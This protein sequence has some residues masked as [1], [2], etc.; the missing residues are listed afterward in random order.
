MRIPGTNLKFGL[1]NCVI[2]GKYFGQKRP[3]PVLALFWQY[4]HY[5]QKLSF[6]YTS[7]AYICK[8]REKRVTF[9]RNSFL[10]TYTHVTLIQAKTWA[11]VKGWGVGGAQDPPLFWHTCWGPLSLWRR[12][13]SLPTRKRLYSQLYKAN[14]ASRTIKGPL[15]GPKRLRGIYSMLWRP[16]IR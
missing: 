16:K 2:N 4:W 10:V 5:H 9:T 12:G 7:H 1:V 13:P 11:S 15:E 3:L 6:D 8:F 14:S